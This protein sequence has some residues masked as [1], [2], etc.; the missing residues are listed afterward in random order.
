[1]ILLN[2]PTRAAD[3]IHWLPQVVYS[4]P[5]QI[6]L[7]PPLV[8]DSRCDD[9]DEYD[10]VNMYLDG[11]PMSIKQY[12]GFPAD[13]VSLYLPW[14]FRESMELVRACDEKVVKKF[15]LRDGDTQWARWRDGDPVIPTVEPA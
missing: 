4:R 6:F 3:G 14:D 10:G 12:K 7:R 2:M 11:I 9:L 15:R 5:W 1:M 13:T 8:P